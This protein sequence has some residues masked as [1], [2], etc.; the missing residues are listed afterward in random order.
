MR[1]V[2]ATAALLLAITACAP[3]DS[4]DTTTDSVSD[5][6][7]IEE[8]RTDGCQAARL[9]I[10][11]N[12]TRTQNIAERLDRGFEGWLEVNKEVWDIGDDIASEGQL[13]A[14]VGLDRDRAFR[15]AGMRVASAY[16]KFGEFL[17]TGPQWSDATAHFS[18]SNAEL[19]LALEEFA[20]MC[21]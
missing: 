21:P 8:A 13:M 4:D 11:L 10:Q 9:V 16:S 5:A 20:D 17:S 1:P 15:A 12:L 6:R 2:A 7:T 19:V 14:S 18:E 3:S